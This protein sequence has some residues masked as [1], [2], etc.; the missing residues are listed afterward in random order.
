M[1]L[2]TYAYLLLVPCVLFG[3]PVE[4]GAHAPAHSSSRAPAHNR[5]GQRRSGAA[6]RATG[7]AAVAP[8]P[9]GGASVRAPASRRPTGGAEAS[10]GGAGAAAGATA[11][12]SALSNSTSQ[13]IWQIQ[14]SG[15]LTHCHGTR[16]SQLARQQNISIQVMQPNAGPV[17]G[18]N[19]GA[20]RRPSGAERTR[21]TVTLTQRRGITQIQIGCQAHCVNSTRTH[22]PIPN[23][24]W[25]LLTRIL[26]GLPGAL[27]AG[28]LSM[29]GEHNEVRQTIHQA[30]SGRASTRTQTQRASQT[31]TTVQTVPSPS[32][33]SGELATG[34]TPPPAASVAVDFSRQAIW[35]V[36][37]GCLSDCHQTEQSQEA[38][39]LNTSIQVIV[40]GVR[41]RAA[42]PSSTV[43]AVST[44]TQLTWQLQIGCLF[45][46]D[47]A[48][49]S[50]HT[51]GSEQ[52]A[53]VATG[54]P[55][56]SRAPAPSQEPARTP[57]EAELSG[58]RAS[59]PHKSGTAWSLVAHLTP[60]P[61]LR[62]ALSRPVAPVPVLPGWS[63]DCRLDP[64]R[65]VRFAF[66]GTE[67]R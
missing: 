20:R 31:N 28:G 9:S 19:A 52:A 16:Q 65:C 3:L 50:Q 17:A 11:S 61:P 23:G 48:T 37:I 14:L 46:C 53:Q 21:T 38:T 35:Q 41:S 45:W 12:G 24:L 6:S 22:T 44:A 34:V 54:L 43:A 66:R 1:T 8:S 5:A 32:P 25:R 15:C 67:C 39:Q 40:P 51:T 47:G 58:P 13:T 42:T 55:A 56:G 4:A 10:R 2:R 26:R 33:P 59:G 18:P 64:A 62:R 36:Q 60:A 63:P 29:P 49:E 27:P 57:A 30:Q 7:G